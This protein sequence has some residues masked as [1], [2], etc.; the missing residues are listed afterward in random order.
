MF[1]AY[2]REMLCPT[3]RDG[4]IV[5]ADK[6]SA[7]KATGVQEAIMA[8]GARLLSRPAYSPD[9]SPTERCWSKI[10]AF[11]RAATARTHEALDAAVT[12]VLATVTASDA[13]AWFAHRGYVLR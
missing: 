10:K 6:L 5:R 2:G 4:D 3:L 7:Y 12:R 9:L 11:L 8:T 13:G 1:R